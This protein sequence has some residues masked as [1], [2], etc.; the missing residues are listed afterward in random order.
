MVGTVEVEE[1]SLGG[2][3]GGV[4]SNLLCTPRVNERKVKPMGKVII[5]YLR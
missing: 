1:E 5:D 4:P 2:G 3:G